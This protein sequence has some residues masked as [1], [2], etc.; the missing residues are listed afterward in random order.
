MNFPLYQPI[1]R[2]S[3]GHT[4]EV[5]R[6][7]RKDLELPVA[8]KLFA[9]G[10][11]LDD[12]EAL[13]M[14]SL[15]MNEAAVLPWLQH[16]SILRFFDL[17]YGR[18]GEMAIV[19]EMLDG[20]SL[21]GLSLAPEHAG[22][23]AVRILGAIAY[24]QR[25]LQI[26]QRLYPAIVHGDIKPSNI[27]LTQD[28]VRLIDFGFACPDPALHD[29]AILGTS[30]FLSPARRQGRDPIWKDDAYALAVSMFDVMGVR[31]EEG[32]MPERSDLRNPISKI[33]A[34]M[35][36]EDFDHPNEAIATLEA[37]IG[38]HNYGPILA[39]LRK[40][41]SRGLSNISNQEIRP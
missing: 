34:A 12:G 15:F 32:S 38:D 31:L 17:A 25:P 2:I 4:S 13:D 8:L 26:G 16:P 28:G 23:V 7:Y 27:M 20:A 10:P 35:M 41:P 18:D 37:R 5:W 33:F 30:R 40:S 24:M 29:R 36:A 14:Q 1:E 22:M 21:K 11:D 19:T 3:K 9:P 6:A 39:A